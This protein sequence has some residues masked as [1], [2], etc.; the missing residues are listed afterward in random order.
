MSDDLPGLRCLMA[1]MQTSRYFY[2]LMTEEGFWKDIAIARFVRRKYS[3]LV[4]K[5]SW[6]RTALF[7]HLSGAGVFGSEP[8]WD[9]LVDDA[10]YAQREARLLQLCD[11]RPVHRLSVSGVTNQDLYW[12]WY[13]ATCPLE[14][15]GEF[16]AGANLL[17]A[18]PRL[19]KEE[20]IAQY[21]SLQRPALIKGLSADWNANATWQRDAFLAK[22]G[23]SWF[24]TNGSDEDGHNFRMRVRDFLTYSKRHGDEK[25]I[26]LFDNKF[27]DHSKEM[28]RSRDHEVVCPHIPSRLGSQVKSHGPP[29]RVHSATGGDDLCSGRLVAHCPELG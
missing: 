18:V 11:Q 23:N 3:Q 17:H 13:R 14:Q 27:S 1:L 25:A 8:V 16:P 22:Y 21:D 7:G 12:K 9:E 5:G 26:Y 2:M 28:R 4:Y 15:F 19:S 6:R 20:F 29:A 10:A 24:K